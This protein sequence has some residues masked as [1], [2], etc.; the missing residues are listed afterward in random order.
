MAKHTLN[1]LTARK[2]AGAKD[3]GHYLDGGLYLRASEFGT[4]SWMF[5][6][7]RQGKARE[8]GL[9]VTLAKAW[10]R[11]AEARARGA[12]LSTRARART[13][14]C[15]RRAHRQRGQDFETAWKPA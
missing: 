9:G 11:A 8:M 14:P 2:V 6:Y 7:T 1:R 10:K 4:R 13:A 15:T 3:R 5:R 12:T